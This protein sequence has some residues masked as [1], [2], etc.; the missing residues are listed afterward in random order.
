MKP[1]VTIPDTDEDRTITAAARADP[2]SPPLD[3]DF[4]DR[5]RRG[6]QTLDATH[7]KKRVNVTLDQELIDKARAKDIN[8]SARVNELLRQDLGQ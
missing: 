5:A 1:K 3:D 4:F 7:K 2:D 8:L 6:R